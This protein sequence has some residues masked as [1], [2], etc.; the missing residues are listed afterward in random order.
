MLIERLIVGCSLVLMLT[1]DVQLLVPIIIFVFVGIFVLV[2]KPYQE[3]YHS[4]RV[5][6]NMFIASVIMAIYL[7]YKSTTASSRKGD[8]FLYL[9]MLVVILLIICVLY[10]VVA[11]IYNFYLWV[12]N[13]KSKY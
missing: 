7:S 8:V 13:R 5:L 3:R 9:P 4:W 2:K 6:A 10:N 12:E 11:M 1:V